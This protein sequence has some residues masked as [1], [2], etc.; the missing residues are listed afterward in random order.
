MQG[1]SSAVLP[2]GS[3][4][5]QRFAGTRPTADTRASL[6]AAITRAHRHAAPGTRTPWAVLPLYRGSIRCA[7]HA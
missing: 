5:A 7:V 4:S 1:G 2:Y 6:S 3:H